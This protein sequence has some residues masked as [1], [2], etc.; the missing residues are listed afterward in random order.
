MFYMGF[1]SIKHVQGPI[2]I[3]QFIK[4]KIKIHNAAAH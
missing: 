4:I 2:Y 1:W 3:I